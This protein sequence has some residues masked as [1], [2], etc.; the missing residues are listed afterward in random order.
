MK[1]LSIL[2]A[3]DHAIIREGLKS[4]IK[5]QPDM[6]VMGEADNGRAAL[7]QARELQPDVL[8]M[9]ISM[10][11]INGAKVTELLAK[12]HPQIKVLALTVHE[13]KGY[14]RQLLKAGAAG[15]VLKRAAAHELI[16]AIRAVASGGTYL[17]PMMTNKIVGDYVREKSVRDELLQDTLS[18]REIEVL[19][20]IAEGHS[21]KEI[22][23]R[24]K[25]SV[26]T[27][28]TYKTR[29][30]SKLGFHSRT[31][32]VRYALDQGWLQGT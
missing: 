29:L 16:H 30:M 22:A 28:E 5:S 10:P 2:L 31:E 7:Q 15:Y 23:S 9:D 19:R 6:E 20:L 26:K 17:D 18:E 1:K 25:L 24:L 3:D 11:E 13:D 32:I 27:V 12:E 8:V 14:L 4:L 21:N